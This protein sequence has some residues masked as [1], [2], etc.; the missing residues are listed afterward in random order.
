MKFI[1]ALLITFSP[2]M[3]AQDV[4]RYEL[5]S[6]KKTDVDDSKDFWDK[7][8]ADTSYV[9]GKSP[10]TSLARNADYLPE[11]A[12]ILDVGMGEGR[13][14][15]FLARRGH[16]V[17]GVDISQ[18]AIQKARSLATEFG[19]R[20][21]TVAKSMDNFE[22]ADGTFDA[23]ICYYYVDK[24]IHEK[25]LRWLRPGGLLFYE[26]YTTAQKN[27]PKSQNL[28]PSYL[29]APGELLKLFPSMKVLKYEEPEHR[30]EFTTFLIAKKLAAPKVD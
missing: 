19:V 27:N 2:L 1:V 26:A 11:S 18:V 17:V 7:R 25:L 22:A 4:A 24:D 3:L 29:L 28:D 21:E 12:H 15:V 8:Y 20:L 13:N 9:Y 23:I 6:G 14:A 16:K 10:A 30:D 5:L